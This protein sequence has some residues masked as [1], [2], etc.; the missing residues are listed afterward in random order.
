MA[1]RRWG[2]R[3]TMRRGGVAAAV[4][5]LAVQA[6]VAATHAPPLLAGFSLHHSSPCHAGRSTHHSSDDPT[7][8]VCPHRVPPCFIC[9]SLHA[10][11]AALPQETNEFLTPLSW[12]VAVYAPYDGVFGEGVDY[13]A[14]QPRGPPRLA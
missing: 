2:W 10:T 11:G 12:R 3:A 14:S 4:F 1:Q 5:A 13:L 7:A 8:P 9:Q 6:I